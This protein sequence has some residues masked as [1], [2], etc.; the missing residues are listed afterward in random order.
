MNLQ[1]WISH[2][3]VTERKREIYYENSLFSHL[4]IPIVRLKVFKQRIKI[5]ICNNSFLD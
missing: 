1:R 4:I 5:I 3:L 2:F